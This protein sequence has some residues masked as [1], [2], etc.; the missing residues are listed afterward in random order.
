MKKLLPAV[1]MLTALAGCTWY[2]TDYTQENA[3]NRAIQK[4]IEGCKMSDDHAAY[5]ECLIQTQ[6]NNSPK[7]Y[8]T[9]ELP[10]GE[11]LAIIRGTKMKETEKEVKVVIEKVE[12]LTPTIV[13]K[14]VVKEEPKVVVK[15]EPKVVVKEEAKVTVK[16]EV[17]EEPKVVVKEE[18]K[19][20]VKEEIKEE[21]KAPVVTKKVEPKPEPEKTWWETYQAN[22]SIPQPSSC[23]CD[24]PNVSCPQCHEK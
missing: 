13:E 9:S 14:I 16:E 3:E 21:P 15:E 7:T 22:K 23:N 6:L 20:T 18:V 24:D 11:P 8:T 17:K 19:V 2:Q 1:L 10:N 12:I 4:S 5:R